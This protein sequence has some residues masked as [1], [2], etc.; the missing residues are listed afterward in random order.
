MSEEPTVELIE[1]IP[2]IEYD[3][4]EGQDKNIPL[5]TTLVCD[6]ARY[7]CQT[8]TMEFKPTFM[9]T[10]RS[11]KLTIKNTSLIT[12]NYNFKIVNSS[13][14]ILDAGP[15]SIIPKKGSIAAGCDDNFV[16]KFS[17]EEVEHDFSRIL[18]ANIENLAPE[19]NPL[20]VEVNGIAE[21]PFI[22]FEL[23]P[24]SYKERKEKDMI[25]VD[26][27]YK[28][29][30]FESLGTN[31]KNTKRFMAVNPT[32]QGYEFEWEEIPD[33]SKK[34]KPMFRCMTQKG[35][36]LSGKKFEMVFEYTPDN[37]GEHESFWRF[38]IKQEN[39]KQE[40]LIV[41]RVIE[42]NVLLGTGKIKFNPLLLDGKN[43]ETVSI[44]NQEQIP[45]SFNFSKE[46]VK[47]SPDYGDS[48]VV[49]PISGVVPAQ[50]SIP[51]EILFQPKYELTYNYNL[52]CNVKRKARPLVLNV[53]GEGYKIH[54]SIYADINRVQVNA[55]DPYKFDYGDF[56]INEK[57]TKIVYLQNNGN[58]NFDYVWKQKVNKYISITP[59]TGTVQ[60]N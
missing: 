56:F 7:E 46:S 18:S 1:T 42:P 44:I 8:Q 27:K 11:Y 58:F 24:S 34:L 10:S 17:P 45:F 21:R 47:G 26:N 54:H 25:P 53:K 16:V 59:E 41:G 23:P 51:I 50:G 28:I 6:Y 30:E 52:I 33:E 9:Y 37:V 38:A 49:N 29:I 19:L 31:I 3:K 12:I 48:L 15:Y 14:G 39:I 36:I 22:H 35:V 40:F 55:T 32:N 60:Q 57:K 43:R 2:E 20:I 13:T 4:I 5:K